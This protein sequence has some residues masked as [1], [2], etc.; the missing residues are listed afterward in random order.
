MFENVLNKMLGKDEFIQIYYFP[1][2]FEISVL[3]KLLFDY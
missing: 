3:L 1:L 2:S